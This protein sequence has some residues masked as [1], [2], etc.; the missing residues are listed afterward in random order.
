MTKRESFRDEDL[1]AYLDG[2]ADEALRRDI[3]DALTYDAKL[4]SR[5]NALMLDRDSLVAEWDTLL[6][7]APPP[8]EILSE[9]VRGSR[10]RI[11]AYARF[12]A[13]AAV[14]VALFVGGVTGF[15]VP[16]RSLESWQAYAAAYHALYVED[17]LS[18]VTV[19]EAVAEEQLARIGQSLGKNISLE[20]LQN[21]DRL[22]YK[23]GQVLGF[24]GQ[25]VIQLAFLS[26]GKQPI[27]LCIRPAPGAQDRSLEPDRMFDMSAVQWTKQG[28][29]YLLVGGQDDALLKSF[30]ERF[31]ARI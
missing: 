27:A 12:G 14:I 13:A 29:E 16:D 3:D 9:P 20:S 19:S 10:T 31:V 4:Q 11:P 24:E 2:E 30:A 22:E 5:L 6:S 8:P 26:D 23:R 17:T 15:Y 1:T 28:F 7:D 25:P 21:V 18:H